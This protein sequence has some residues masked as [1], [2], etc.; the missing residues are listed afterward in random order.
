M[1]A[2]AS[3]VHRHLF[4]R[5][6][7]FFSRSLLVVCLTV[8]SLSWSLD[9]PVLAQD[10]TP[11][12]PALK[13]ADE[14]APAEIRFGRAVPLP[15]GPKT[16][17]I[18]AYNVLNLFDPVDDPTLSGKYDDLPM[19]T[20]RDRCLAIAKVIKAIDADVLALEEV[21]SK[22]AIEWFRDE[23]LQGLGYDHV[24]SLD[25]GYYRGVEQ[26]VLS[27]FP[28]SGVTA[29]PDES[30]ADMEAKKTGDG[31]E[32]KGDAPKS[33]QRSPLMVDIEVPESSDHP[34]YSFTLA[35]VHHKSGN[36]KRQRESEALQLVELL[37]S[38][39]E[40]EPELNLIILGDFNAG[41]FDQSVA[42]Y[43]NAGFVNA[44]EH[45][46]SREEGT[47]NLFRTHESDRVIDYI[48]LHP[49]ADS[50]VAKNTF[51]VVG[52]LHPG[53]KYN[54]RKDE[55]PSGYAADH[56]PLVIDLV[57]QDRRVRTGATGR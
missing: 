6:S 45:R 14:S 7:G 36:F 52:S 32:T 18:A 26:S 13:N 34:A 31:W 51:Q 53:D 33:F 54:W 15:K 27:R 56:Y 24:A 8:L 41:P 2:T 25:V 43:K 11:S 19:A 39:L 22:E 3:H 48:M 30:L 42:V 46:W 47:R 4:E 44:Y 40:E 12:T 38:R 37:Q 5:G 9:E 21:E 49:N 16:I 17:R 50:E 29:W 35:V 55:P 23:F 10:T 1:N 20:S 28:I 57:P